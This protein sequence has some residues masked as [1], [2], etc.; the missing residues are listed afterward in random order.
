[1]HAQ[2]LYDREH[3]E[4]FAT[5][6]YQSQQY[7]PAAREYER[8]YILEKSA[9]PRSELFK[10]YR[11]AGKSLL[12]I[13]RVNS[14]YPNPSSYP[15]STYFELSRMLLTTGQFQTYSE[16]IPQQSFLTLSDKTLLKSIRS[17]YDKKYDATYDFLIDGEMEFYNRSMVQVHHI[18]VDFS[19][20]KWKSPALAASLSAVVPGLGRWYAGD[21]KN[22]IVSA[23]F[24]GINGY[25]SYRGFSNS[26]ISSVGGWIFG[27]IGLG[28]YVGNIYGAAWTANRKNDQK[29]D[30]YKQKIEQYYFSF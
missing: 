9:H 19:S 1:M 15:P 2:N 13:N 12:G 4:R 21:W 22:A 7:E 26:G 17:V 5:F 10:S 25:Q 24:V 29:R 18:M 16:I 8:L 27:A 14:I 3:T 28:F 20:E 30:A 23:I 11:L 6:L